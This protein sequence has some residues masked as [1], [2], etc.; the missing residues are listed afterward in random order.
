MT[1]KQIFYYKIFDDK[2]RLNYMKSSLPHKELENLLK[3]Y[4]Q[5]HQ[6]YFNPEFIQFLREK[7][8]EAELIE[9]SDISY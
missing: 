5:N 7:D 2:E 3:E 8:A 4:E 9:V 6:K 1:D